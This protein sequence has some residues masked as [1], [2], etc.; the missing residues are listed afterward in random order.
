MTVDLLVKHEDLICSVA[1]KIALKLN[2]PDV[3]ELISFGRAELVNKAHK[4]NSERGAFSTFAT[5]VLR[6]AMLDYVKRNRRLVPCSD[7]N[8]YRA[9]GWVAGGVDCR[10]YNNTAGS[11]VDG[12]VYLDDIAIK[13]WMAMQTDERVSDSLPNRL[14]D[15]K[16]GCSTAAREVLEVCLEMDFG[17]VFGKRSAIE[18]LRKVLITKGW[19]RRQT[20]R[21]FAEISTLVAAW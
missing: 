1:N 11:S 19:D 5:W 7:G 3:D 20:H 4:W 10:H 17:N 14:D 15:L 16:K 13:D 18:R 6:N 8:P 9:M 12:G 21:V 2:F